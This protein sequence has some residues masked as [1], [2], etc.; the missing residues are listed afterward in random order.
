MTQVP[1]PGPENLSLEQ[2]ELWRFIVEGPRAKSLRQ[3]VTALPGPFGPWLQ[4][5]S[6]GRCAAEMGEILRFRSILSGDLREIAI[7]TVGVHW[8]A[9]F[10]FWAHSAMA[11][12]EGVDETILQALQTGQDPPFKTPQQQLVHSAAVQLLTKGHLPP[13]LRDRMAEELGWP[14]TVELVALIGYYCMVSFTLNAFDV[15]LPE[16]VAHY[17]RREQT[18]PL[19]APTTS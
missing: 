3:P 10:E 9:E 7:L 1:Q 15:G 8:K 18:A 5:P 4:I 17:W 19:P 13:T 2:A 14:A 16:G 12:S 6:V 11:R